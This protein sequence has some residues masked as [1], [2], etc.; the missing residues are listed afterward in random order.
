MNKILL[1]LSVLI[2][3]SG[4]VSGSKKK[5]LQVKVGLVTKIFPSTIN[6]KVGEFYSIKLNIINNTDSTVRFWRLSCW[7]EDNWVFTSKNIVFHYPKCYKNSLDIEEILSGKSLTYSGILQ[8]INN[9][10]LNIEKGFK[11]GLI[12]VKDNEYRMD[13]DFDK[14]LLDKKNRNKDIIWCDNPIFLDKM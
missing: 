1:T 11:L 8:V 14:I 4:C 9:K 2:L 10:N 13:M 6:E 12:L 3:L 7:W 5:S